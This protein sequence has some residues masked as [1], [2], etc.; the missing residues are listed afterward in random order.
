MHGTLVSMD[1]VMS[2]ASDLQAII[3]ISSKSVTKKEGDGFLA[4]SICKEGYTYSFFF[5]NQPA[6][7]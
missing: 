6:P 4:D 7:A 1:P 5:R 3:R 2:N